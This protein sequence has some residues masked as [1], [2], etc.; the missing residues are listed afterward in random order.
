[1][2]TVEVRDT[3]TYY[4]DHGEGQPIVFVHGAGSDHRIWAE[5][6]APLTDEYRVVV[7]DVRGHGYTDGGEG[8]FGFDDY[9]EDLHALVA[10]LEL[11]DPVVCGLSMGGM[12]GFAYAARYPDEPAGLVTLG[13]RTPETFS[14]TEYA[15]TRGIPKVMRAASKVVDPDRVEGAFHWVFDRIFG[16]ETG[17]DIEEAE[18]IQEAYDPDVPELSDEAGEKMSVAL[19]DYAAMD[20][21]L[22]AIAVPTLAMYGELEM[23]MAAEHAEHVAEQAP[24]AEAREIPDAGHNSHVDNPEFIRDAIRAFVR[25]RVEPSAAAR[26]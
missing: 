4:E 11:E 23:A 21:A 17:G 12:I 22:D 2:P 8:E 7:Y 3:E 9:V 20:L 5:R 24:D 6:T 16:E 10:E 19:D 15:M 18:R 25:E 13:A 14:W 1:M 26:R